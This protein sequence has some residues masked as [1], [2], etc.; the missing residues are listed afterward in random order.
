MELLPT[1]TES[2]GLTMAKHNRGDL[3]QMQS[4]PLEAKIIMTEQRIRV[5]VDAWK[6]YEIVNK[7]TG[8]KR[9]VTDTE[10]PTEKG[11]WIK[12]EVKKGGVITV[13]EK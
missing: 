6:R 13:R 10:E 5:W 3:Q 1:I 7:K 11:H 12:K 9:Y 4:L 8:R 2:E